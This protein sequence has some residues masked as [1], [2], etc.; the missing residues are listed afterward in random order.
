[1]AAADD[2]G[3]VYRFFRVGQTF[4]PIQIWLY[5]DAITGGTDYDLGLYRTAEDGGAVVDVD[6]FATAVSMASARTTSPI[7]LRHEQDNI[8]TVYDF[9]TT[10]GDRDERR[11]TARTGRRGTSPPRAANPWPPVPRRA[12]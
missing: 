12:A 9:P 5:N 6:R 11:A 10:A 4:A 3:S 2:D 8:N 1:M 7:D